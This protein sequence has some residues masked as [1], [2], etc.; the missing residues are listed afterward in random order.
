LATSQIG[1]KI[2]DGSFYPVLEEGSREKKRLVVTTVKDDQENVHIDLYRSA[3]ESIDDAEYVG[4][5]VIEN[6]QPAPGGDPEVEVVLGIDENQNLNAVASDR[7]TGNR[8]SLS[9]SLQSLEDIGDYTIPDFELD[10]EIPAPEAEEPEQ[11]DQEL[12]GAAYP[13][14]EEDRR[15]A[16]LGRGKNNLLRILFVVVGILVIAGI[17]YL[18]YR[19]FAP[20]ETEEPLQAGQRVELAEEPAESPEQAASAEGAAGESAAG[21]SEA[22]GAGSGAA[23][24][25]EAEAS[26]ESGDASGAPAGGAPAAAPSA[27]EAGPSPG[28]QGVWYTIK[29]GD[30]LW[31]ISATYYRN[32]WLYPAIAEHPEND[33]QDPDFILAG[34]KLFI[35]KR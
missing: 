32:P 16:H 2:A 6:I 7:A 31:D 35:P 5:L 1:I 22:G 24:E 23:G 8:Q 10:E 13:I 19:V 12:T 15:K 9:T 27:A 34:F 17:T 4:S 11:E 28:D 33:I 25:S 18:L 21:E 3:A 30:T 14:G 20:D 29:W 26:A